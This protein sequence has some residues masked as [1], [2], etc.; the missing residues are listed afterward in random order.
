[1]PH[2]GS[3]TLLSPASARQA[4]LMSAATNQ[5]EVTGRRRLTLA[6]RLTVCGIIAGLVLVASCDLIMVPSR[7][8]FG[9]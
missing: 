8:G 9:G 7:W 3:E 2:N 4:T 1:M 5:R 6:G